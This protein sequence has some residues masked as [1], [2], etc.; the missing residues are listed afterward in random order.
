[1]AKSPWVDRDGNCV[2]KF[3]GM[4][5]F[6]QQV[7]SQWLERANGMETSPW[8]VSQNLENVNAPHLENNGRP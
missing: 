5:E 1:M 6:S 4:N 8:P 3:L 2:I 7:L